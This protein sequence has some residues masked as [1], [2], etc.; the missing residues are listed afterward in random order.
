MTQWNPS[1]N[2]FMQ[3]NER[4]TSRTRSPRGKSPSGRMSRW[5]CK[6][7]LKGTCNNSFCERWHPPE[8]LFYK[9]KSGCRFR[10]KCSYAHRQV[11]EQPT[12]MSKKNDDKSAVA[13][14]GKGD[15]HERRLVTDQ[16]HDR[17]GKPDRRSDKKLGQKSCKRRSSDARHG[18]WQLVE[19]VLIVFFHDSLLP[20]SSVVDADGTNVDVRVKSVLLQQDSTNSIMDN[21]KVVREALVIKLLDRFLEC[22]HVPFSRNVFFNGTCLPRRGQG[23]QLRMLLR[24]CSSKQLSTLLSRQSFGWRRSVFL[25]GHRENLLWHFLSCVC[26]WLGQVAKLLG[27]CAELRMSCAFRTGKFVKEM[28]RNVMSEWACR[29]GNDGWNMRR[30]KVRWSDMTHMQQTPFWHDL[31]HACMCT[32]MKMC[33]CD[34]AH[35][36]CRKM[37]VK[38]VSVCTPPVVHTVVATSSVRNPQKSVKK[39]LRLHHSV[40][41]LIFPSGTCSTSRLSINHCKWRFLAFPRHASLRDRS[42]ES[43]EPYVTLDFPKFADQNNFRSSYSYLP[44]FTLESISYSPYL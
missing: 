36:M 39:N 22:N 44:R 20:I 26:I 21:M 15:W 12:K 18:R 10:E 13:M 6:D 37:C 25:H 19:P 16:C 43:S 2:S 17:S 40:S 14:L 7:Y 24:V 30:E 32:R 4:K 9:T 5:P 11:D 42:P 34:C 8:C 28:D 33:T 29:N 31:S 3:Q 35:A 38:Q 1:P 41:F 23:F 27:A